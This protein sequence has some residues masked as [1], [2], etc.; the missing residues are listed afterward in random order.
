ME[1]ALTPYLKE[2]MDRKIILLTGPRQSGKTTISKMITPD[3]DYLNHD[4][5]EH[6]LLIR[7]KAW[8]RSKELIILDELHKMKDWKSWLKGI[9]DTEGLTPKILVTGSAKLDT[10]RKMG[11]SLA[12]R[13]FQ[14]RLHPLDIREI[15]QIE[16]KQDRTLTQ[17][18]IRTGGFP[19]PFLEGTET[20]YNRW[21]R[22]HSDII[23]R[24]DML[25]LESL[26]HISTIET[27]IQLLRQRVGSP[28]SWNSL[29]RDLGC[30]DKS[31][32]KWVQILEEMYVIFQIHP[33]HRNVARALLKSPKIY[34]YDTGQVLG[35]SGSQLENMVACSLLKEIH[36]RQDCLGQNYD[37]NY[38]RTKNGQE[39][40]FLITHD[41]E[42]DT[43]I[44]VK[45]AD[46]QPSRH[47]KFF[48]QYLPIQRQI[49]L[50]EELNREKTYPEGLEIRKVNHW[51]S[52]MP[53]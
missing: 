41:E 7:E 28:V 4:N 15:S 50:V 26:Q 24:Q 3:Y 27:L 34:F 14:Y 6:R 21:K 32:K 40:D 25:E 10:Y 11:D 20:F 31:V 51:L 52:E 22:S 53:F 18:M 13:Y 35:D 30:S 48:S 17:Q 23:L 47:F 49:Q 16:G 45:W 33:F 44:E 43:L 46:D 38:V 29:A 2:Y 37:L 19:E 5:H 39:I 42:P 1:R 36:F 12:G 8:D 9:Y